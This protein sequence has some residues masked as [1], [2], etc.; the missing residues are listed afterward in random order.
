MRGR[1]VPAAVAAT[2]AM[3]LI[4]QPAL[5]TFYVTGA[6]SALVG[7]GLATAAPTGADAA[8]FVR[9]PAPSVRTRTNE[10]QA[11]TAPWIEANAWRFQRGL[12]KAH[13]E[14]LPAGSAVSAA[15]EA[16]AF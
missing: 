12:K 4:G 15:A 7:Q 16:W 5:G 2:W 6:G 8:E 13:Y 9:V 11:T 10:A 1:L 14:N 3:A